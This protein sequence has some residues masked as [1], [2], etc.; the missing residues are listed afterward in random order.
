MAVEKMHSDY[1]PC[2][3]DKVWE[4]ITNPRKYHSLKLPGV[5][6]FSNSKVMGVGVELKCGSLMGGSNWYRYIRDYKPKYLLTIGD[7]SEWHFKFRLKE[8]NSTT[9]NV[10]FYRKFDEL[11]LMSSIFNSKKEHR[12]RQELTRNTITALRYAC[13]SLNRTG[14]DGL[15]LSPDF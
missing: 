15:T 1:M 4:I 11:S 9:T 6:N 5:Y 10:E 13:E 12:D 7:K 14:D 3:I 8:I 2:S